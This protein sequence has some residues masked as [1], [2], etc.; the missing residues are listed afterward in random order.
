MVWE[1]AAGAPH[2]RPAVEVVEGTLI[3]ESVFDGA[4]A[5]VSST[6]SVTLLPQEAPDERRLRMVWQPR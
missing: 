3:R 1:R 6:G 5:A 2:A 4:I